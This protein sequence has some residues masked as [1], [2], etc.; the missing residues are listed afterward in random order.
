MIS[1]K[2]GIQLHD[3]AIRGESLTGEEKTQLEA[4]YAFQDSTESYPVK[5]SDKSLTVLR[6]QIEAALSQLHEN[7]R[8]LL[9]KTHR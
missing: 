6:A 2:P 4:W 5:Y 1:D 7:T 3:K 9:K 8:L